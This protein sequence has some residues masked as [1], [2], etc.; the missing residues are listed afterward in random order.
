ME[1][2]SHSG[3]RLPR[4]FPLSVLEVFGSLEM[5]WLKGV[6]G[7]AWRNLDGNLLSDVTKCMKVT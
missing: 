2:Y 4:G 5:S 6:S 1:S 7:V 3:F